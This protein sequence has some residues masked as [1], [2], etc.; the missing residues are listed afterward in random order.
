MKP[1]APAQN[2]SSPRLKPMRQTAAPADRNIAPSRAKNGPCGPCNSRKVRRSAARFICHV[3]LAYSGRFHSCALFASVCHGKM[4]ALRPRGCRARQDK[5]ECRRMFTGIIT[6]I[7][8]V[9]A[10]AVEGDL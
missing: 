9:I 8:E 3:L 10:V 5:T 6:D 1:G 2:A 7:G 4:S